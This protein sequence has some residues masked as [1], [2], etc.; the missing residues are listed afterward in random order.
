MAGGR[1]RCGCGAVDKAN[2]SLRH[3]QS[4]EKPFNHPWIHTILAESNII[5][6]AEEEMIRCVHRCVTTT[7]TEIAATPALCALCMACCGERRPLLSIHHSNNRRVKR[8]FPISLFVCLFVDAS[9]R[10]CTILRGAGLDSIDCAARD[11]IDIV[12]WNSSRSEKRNFHLLK[13]LPRRIAS[14]TYVQLTTPPGYASTLVV[15]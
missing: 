7:V 2:G 8:H 9:I 3:R 13:C 14:D 15:L 11:F 1:G 12:Q 4:Y 10:D 6:K 5:R